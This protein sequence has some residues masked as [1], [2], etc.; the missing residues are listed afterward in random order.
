MIIVVLF[1]SGRSMNSVKGAGLE[2]MGSWHME[3]GLRSKL[4]GSVEL[5]GIWR[6]GH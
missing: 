1:N 6:A 3:A 5:H 2:Y 4:E